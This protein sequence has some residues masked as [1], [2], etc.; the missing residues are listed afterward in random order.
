VGAWH[1]RQGVEG[2]F[3][4]TA[5][6]PAD[7]FTAVV[8]LTGF[9]ILMVWVYDRTQSLFVA[10]LMHASLTASTI[11]LAPLATGVGLV[12]ANLVLAAVPWLILAA[13]AVTRRPRSVWPR[14][15]AVVSAHP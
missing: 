2:A 14:H 12:A 13:A 9:R 4:L 5:F 15:R 3:S 1:F 7:L 11:M 10:M 8:Q 6:L